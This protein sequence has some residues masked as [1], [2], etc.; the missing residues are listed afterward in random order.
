MKA[1]PIDCH[2]NFHPLNFFC[3]PSFLV[4]R[5][6]NAIF[7]A[8]TI[9]LSRRI[10]SHFKTILHFYGLLCCQ[11]SRTYAENNFNWKNTFTMLSKWAKMCMVCYPH[12]QPSFSRIYTC[13]LLYGFCLF[14][15]ALKRDNSNKILFD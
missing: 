14:H 11:S 10:S 3:R 2:T 15:L 1:T 4:F 8:F 6:G 9:T 12:P 13:I 5:H 7:S